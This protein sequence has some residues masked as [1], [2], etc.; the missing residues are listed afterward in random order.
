MDFKNQLK[1]LLFL[2]FYI[3]QFKFKVIHNPIMRVK[4]KFFGSMACGVS[5]Q[6]SGCGQKCSEVLFSI[7]SS[8]QE[9]KPKNYSNLNIPGKW[10]FWKVFGL[11]LLAMT[12]NSKIEF[13]IL[14]ATS[15]HLYRPPTSHTLKNS[16][17]TLIMGLWITSN[18]N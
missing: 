10:Q 16:F 4:K 18:S 13:T 8:C 2:N 7:C 17:L 15:R 14:L 5:I 9:K 6:M 3:G 1:K 12:L 11:F